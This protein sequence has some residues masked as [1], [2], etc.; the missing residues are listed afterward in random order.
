MDCPSD[1]QVERDEDGDDDDA[2]DDEDGR[3]NE[4]EGRGKGGGHVLLKE[5]GNGVEHLRQSAGLLADGDHVGGEAGEDAGFGERIGE[6]FALAHGGDGGFDGFGDAARGDRARGGFQRG[7]EGQAAGAAW[8]GCA[9][10]GPP[11]T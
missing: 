6:A 5:F 9:R 8:R 10:R 4:G 11:G 7:H 3:L 2:H 1:G